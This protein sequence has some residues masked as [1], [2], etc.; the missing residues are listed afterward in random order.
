MHVQTEKGTLVKTL[1]EPGSAQIVQA[2]CWSPQGTPLVTADR[3]GLVTFW[4][5]TP[6]EE[7]IQEDHRSPRHHHHSHA[8]RHTH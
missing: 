2:A 8:G 4:Q 7:T 6:E 1:K 5:P 3:N